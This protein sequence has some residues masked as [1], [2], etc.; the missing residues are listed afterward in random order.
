MDYSKPAEYSKFTK[1]D[2]GLTC[3]FIGSSLP[4]D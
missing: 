1:L 4:A 2:A 3:P